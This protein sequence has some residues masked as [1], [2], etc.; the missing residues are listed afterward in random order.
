MLVDVRFVTAADYRLQMQRRSAAIADAANLLAL[1]SFPRLWM[2]E[3]TMDWSPVQVLATTEIVN[4]KST[5]GFHHEGLG[6]RR[7][8][9]EV[10]AS[11]VRTVD[12]DR[13]AAGPFDLLATGEVVVPD[14]L[15]LLRSRHRSMPSQRRKQASRALAWFGD[16]MRTRN[17]SVRIAC[18]VAA[19]ESLLP[20]SRPATCSQ[21][22][23]PTLALTKRVEE[24]LQA[25]AGEAML[26][27]YRKAVYHLRSRLVHGTWHYEVDAPMFSV[28]AVA[29]VDELI[30][31]GAA[32]ACLLNW[33]LRI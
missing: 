11:D 8:Q 24:L 6:D 28:T 2:P 30:V 4:V 16:G 33:L 20:A 13:F 1:A 15:G 17:I 29:D 19:I 10:T 14:T 32:R 9:P 26:E 22:G 27:E 31:E 5:R 21:C 25:Y 23:Q 3:K 7:D 12:H 18:F